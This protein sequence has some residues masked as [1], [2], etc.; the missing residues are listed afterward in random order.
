VGRLATLADGKTAVRIPRARHPRTTGR[1]CPP[2][3]LPVARR[4]VSRVTGE[5]ADL[6]T[7][8]EPHPLPAPRATALHA[9]G[10]VVDRVQAAAATPGDDGP[11]G[12]RSASSRR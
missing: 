4:T 10:R 2:R 12:Q 11:V 5:L 1:Q 3:T 6:A 8:A 7:A 9:L